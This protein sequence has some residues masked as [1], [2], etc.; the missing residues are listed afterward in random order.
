MAITVT[1]VDF[2]QLKDIW[3]DSRLSLNWSPVFSL[4]PWLETWWDEFKPSAELAL[5]SVYDRTEVIGIAPLQIADG[6][7]SFVGNEDVCDYVDFVVQPGREGDFFAALLPSLKRSEAARLDLKHVRPDS[8]V[9]THFADWA[10]GHGLSVSTQAEA[11]SPALDLPGT[12]EAYLELLS[13]K[14]RHELARKMRRL[15]EM[16]KIAYRNI[17]NDVAPAMDTFFKL[18]TESRRD[19]AA[20][21]TPKMA[22]FFRAIAA[23]MSENGLLRLGRL[24]LDGATIAMVMCFDYHG[25]IYLYNSGY[26]PQYDYLSAGLLCKAL[27][28]KDSIE[29]GRKRFDFLKGNEAYKY[30]LGGKETPLY[31]CRVTI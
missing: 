2:A 24:D 27:C 15:S 17:E 19:K 10:R 23:A 7:A 18:F 20:F 26:D 6:L 12:W 28:I 13:A 11:V 29:R 31:A 14:Q 25:A 9:M 22:S 8:V 1:R 16:G 21:L 3:R 4:P 30:H 5:V